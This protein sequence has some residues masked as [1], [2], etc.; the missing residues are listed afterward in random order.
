MTFMQAVLAVGE[1]VVSALRNGKQALGNNAACLACNNPR[2]FRGSVEL[3]GTLRAAFPNANRWDYG[4]GFA[5]SRSKEVAVWVEVHSA[6]E[7]EVEVI[8]RKLLWLK[9]WLRNSASSLNQL[10]ERTDGSS[11]FFWVATDAGVSI[12]PKSRKAKLLQQAGL[13]LPRRRWHLH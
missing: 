1:P 9:N 6:T 13:D 10:T 2:R 11:A 12:T 5:Q 7:G 8:L 3:D 4:V